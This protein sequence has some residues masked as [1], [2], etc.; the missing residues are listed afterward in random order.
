[1]DAVDAA[2]SP[3]AP[4]VEVRTGMLSERRYRYVAGLVD[5]VDVRR[6]TR[7]LEVADSRTVGLE[8]DEPADAQ[9]SG[10]DETAYVGRTDVARCFAV[11]PPWMSAD[12]SSS[13]PD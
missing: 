2:D 5:V 7:G 8:V 6:A 11:L 12:R 9:F 10:A 13:V 3:P 4:V 1:M